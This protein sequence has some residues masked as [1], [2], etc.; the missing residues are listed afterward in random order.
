VAWWLIHDKIKIN[1]L[2][3]F[4]SATWISDDCH[5]QNLSFLIVMANFPAVSAAMGRINDA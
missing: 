4:F 5:F 3:F 1:I 2:A